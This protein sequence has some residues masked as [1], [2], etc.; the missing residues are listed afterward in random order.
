LLYL[1]TTSVEEPL[2]QNIYVSNSISSYL[3]ASVARGTSFSYAEIWIAPQQLVHEGT[4]SEADFYEPEMCDLAPVLAI[5]TA[6]YVNDLLN[7]H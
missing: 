2:A 1:S 5:H 6:E 3:S 4:A 7:S